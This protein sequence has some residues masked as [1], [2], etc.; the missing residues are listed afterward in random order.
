MSGRITV[1]GG[2]GQI[3]RVAVKALTT[4]DLFDSI[5]IADGNYAEAVK[6]AESLDPARVR[7]G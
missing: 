5:V 7:C 4:N 3:G 6:L 1:F 2:C